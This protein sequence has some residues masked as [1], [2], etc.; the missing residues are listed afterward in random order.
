MDTL[1]KIIE[2]GSALNILLI[3]ILLYVLVKGRFFSINTQHLR[4]GAQEDERAIMRRQ[5]EYVKAYVHSS[6]R[7]FPQGL[8]LNP[9][10]TENILHELIDIFE[11]MIVFNHIRDDHMYIRIKQDII[12]NKVLA[13]TDH[14]F[15]TTPEFRTWCD[16][17]AEKIIKQLVN[18]RST[19]KSSK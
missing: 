10:R 9:V 12:Y 19:Y 2:N 15:F 1:A 7:E 18:I 8:D 4:L 17:T 3:A 13:I 14:Q 11:D 6:V 5:L 16:T